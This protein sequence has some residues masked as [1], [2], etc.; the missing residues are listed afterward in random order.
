MSG[1]CQAGDLFNT[2]PCPVKELTIE[3]LDEALE[4]M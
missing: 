4:A 1:D 3:A 2:D